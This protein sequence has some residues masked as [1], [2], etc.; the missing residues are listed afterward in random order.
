MKH[1]IILLILIFKLSII[2]ASECYPRL[3]ISNPST[4][5][6]IPNPYDTIR[7]TL[8]P[9]DTNL[10]FYLLQGGS[11]CPSS[12]FSNILWFKNGSPISGNLQCFN[13]GVGV[14]NFTCLFNLVSMNVTIV[15]NLSSTA[16]GINIPKESPMTGIRLFPNPNVT[17]LFNLE[18]EKIENTYSISI[19][20]SNGQFIEKQ[21]FSEQSGVLDLS[22][23]KRGLYFLEFIFENGVKSHQ[24]VIYD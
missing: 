19:Y 16:T 1:F 20:N 11:G 23:R 10:A 17:G 3:N 24:K 14:Y 7:V 18:N 15:V 5:Q 9:L 8:N 12:A 6:Y 22:E 21:F 4:S 2:N 13:S